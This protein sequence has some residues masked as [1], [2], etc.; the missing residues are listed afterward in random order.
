MSCLLVSSV[1]VRADRADHCGFEARFE[2]RALG[3]VVGELDGA[4]IGVRRLIQPAE[5][6]EQLRTCRPVQ[7]VAVQLGTQRVELL[8]R[9]YRAGDVLQSDGAVE[10]DHRA[11]A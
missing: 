1:A 2:E 6:A 10:A 3:W 4:A 8:H 7:V 5:A 9:R 11:W